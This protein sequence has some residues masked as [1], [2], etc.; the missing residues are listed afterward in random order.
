MRHKVSKAAQ[1]S[2]FFGRNRGKNNFNLKCYLT[3]AVVGII[4]Q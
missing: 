1:T 4:E 2:N 3:F